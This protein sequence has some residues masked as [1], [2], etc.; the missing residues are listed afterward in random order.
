MVKVSYSKSAKSAKGN[1]AQGEDGGGGDRARAF[2]N[3]LPGGP[4]RTRI[5]LPAT[6]VTTR[7]TCCLLGKLIRD[8]VPR[9]PAGGSSHRHPLPVT[10]Q[11]C[12]LPEGEQVFGINHTVCTSGLGPAAAGN[13]LRAEFPGASLASSL[14]EQFQARCQASSARSQ[15]LCSVDSGE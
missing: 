6:T 7:M 2:K 8:S 15:G 10:V 3:T 4:H 9:V 5:I 11:N 12:S 13:T 14:S 1:G